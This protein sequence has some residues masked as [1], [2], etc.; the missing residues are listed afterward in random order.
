MIKRVCRRNRRTPAGRVFVAPAAGKEYSYGRDA[1]TIGSILA[2]TPEFHK[3]ETEVWDWD[4]AE[5]LL[6]AESVRHLRSDRLTCYGIT[7]ELDPICS[8]G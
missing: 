3:S 5:S 2:S 6:S 1:A 7:P 8:R 4:P